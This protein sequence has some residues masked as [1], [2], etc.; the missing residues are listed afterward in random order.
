MT[1]QELIQ[2]VSIHSGLP[3]SDARSA[4]EATIEVIKQ[5]VAKG[6]RVDVRG[7]GSFNRTHRAEKPARIIK[8][9]ERILIPAHYAP[10]FKA[11]TE[12]ENHVK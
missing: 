3:V 8:T 9:G 5:Q 11:S 10:T 4:F 1:K 12:F 6:N 2:M 7:F